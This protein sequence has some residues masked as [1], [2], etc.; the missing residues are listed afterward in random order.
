MTATAPLTLLGA[1][2]ALALAGCVDPIADRCYI[3]RDCDEPQICSNDGDRSRQG[4][5]VDPPDAGAEMA[6]HPTAA[7]KEG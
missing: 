6:A 1:L 2:V 4:F 7:R 3:D 5:C